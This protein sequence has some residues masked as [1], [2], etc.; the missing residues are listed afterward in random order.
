MYSAKDST[1]SLRP[2]VPF[3]NHSSLNAYLHILKGAREAR[4]AEN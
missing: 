3:A 2:A 4:E 1:R